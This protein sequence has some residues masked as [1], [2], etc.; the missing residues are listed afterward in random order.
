[1][2]NYEC[3][4]CGNTTAVIVIDPEDELLTECLACGHYELINDWE[5]GKEG[6]KV[7]AMVIDR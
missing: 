3:L 4:E 5:D 7:F 2:L 1:M 6:Q